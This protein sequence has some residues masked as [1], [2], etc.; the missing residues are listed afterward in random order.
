MPKKKKKSQTPDKG[1]QDFSS[2]TSER[3]LGAETSEQ[4]N[5]ERVL[6]IRISP[7]H[8]KSE[9]FKNTVA[10]S[11]NDMKQINCIDGERVFLIGSRNDS[12]PSV[13]ELKSVPREA[14]G[15]RSPMPGSASVGPL[16]LLN[17]YFGKSGQIFPDNSISTPTTTSSKSTPSK[18]FSFRTA[19]PSTPSTPTSP[20]KQKSA[21]PAKIV[22][23]DS[24]LGYQLSL[25]MCV[26]AK[27]VALDVDESGGVDLRG[28]TEMLKKLFLA[29]HKNSFVTAGQ[30]V[31]MSFRGKFVSLK[32]KALEEDRMEKVIG[33]MERLDIDAEQALTSEGVA[34]LERIDS[35]S[36]S[37]L[38]RIR[39]TTIISIGDED[40]ASDSTSKRDPR[41]VVCVDNVEREAVETLMAPLHLKE[42]FEKSNVK[43]PRGVLLHGPSGTGKTELAMQIMENLKEI[44]ETEFV[45]C[46]SILSKA[47]VVGEAERALLRLFKRRRQ[48]GKVAKLVVFDD[49][50]LI[51]SKRGGPDTSA[52]HLTATLLALLDGT[53]S[54]R[55]PLGEF[56]VL[57]TA[58]NV[59]DLDPAMRRPGRLDTEIEVPLPDEVRFRADIL[60]FH[61]EKMGLCL[62]QTAQDEWQTL[63]RL[64]KGFNGADCMLAVKEAVRTSI[65]RQCTSTPVLVV[66]VEDMKKGIRSTKPSVIKAITVEVPK[67]FWTSIGG[68]ESVK[69]ELREAIELPETHASLY[70]KLKL[71][72]PRGILLYGPPG[73][74]KTLMARALATEGHMNFLAVKGPELLS[75]WLGESERTLANLFRRARMASPCIVFF[76]EI[77]A[78]ATKRGSGDSST[79]SRLLSQLLTELDGISSARTNQDRVVVVGAT[80]RPDLLDR[81]LMRPGRIDRM[82]YVGVPDRE[83]REKII[84]ISLKG[85]NCSSDIDITFLATDDNSKGF[86]G[87]EMVSICR[88]AALLALEEMDENSLDISPKIEMKHLLQAMRETQRQITPSM[89]KFYEDFQN[90][91]L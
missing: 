36:L 80:N 21:L 42:N 26:V 22:P 44:F 31:H 13:C 66:S 65:M 3:F 40:N 56:V 24:T 4:S 20:S 74:S 28:N 46:S 52:D 14:G 29:F 43:K 39:V 6:D 17:Q 48:P 69:R 34:L 68:M 75:K 41:R 63:G 73:C 51:C 90:G 88:D 72:P 15:S 87:A 12:N 50:H 32:I 89:I 78:I 64:A 81:A 38:Y 62:E 16:S 27:K 84:E 83:S 59:S 35:N 61:L 23:L 37:K 54:G 47:G 19:S 58:P 7:V 1:N 85:R 11:S 76:D 18:P 33:D 77:D 67:V 60:Q 71:R 9:L 10:I 5:Y 86:S 79:S 30:S 70:R 25:R 49:I 8:F 45:H 2:E 55:D 82:I 53:Q 57:A 91:R